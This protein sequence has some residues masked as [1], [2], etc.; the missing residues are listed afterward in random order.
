MPGEAD[1]KAEI[2]LWINAARQ[3]SDEAMGRLLETCRKYLLRVA[4]GQLDGALRNRIAAS[5]LV[6]VTCLD[7][8]VSFREQFRGETE[9]ELRAWLRRILLNNLANEVRRLKTDKRD[10]GR[11]VPLAGQGDDVTDPA[12]SP[13]AQ[14]AARE[15]AEALDR[16]IEQLPEEYRQVILLRNREQLAWQEVGQRL[17]R[18]AEAARQLWTRALVKLHEI[19]ESPDGT[20]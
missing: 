20:A 4:D 13:S 14:A 8:C 17:G 16:A 1:S 6:Q 18:S 12:A 9:E 10:V 15:E 5:S 11:E 2:A 19:M 7:A 3:G